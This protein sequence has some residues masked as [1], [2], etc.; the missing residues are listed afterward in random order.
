MLSVRHSGLL[1]LA[2]LTLC[3]CKVRDYDLDKLL[4]PIQGTKYS[5]N[6]VLTFGRNGTAEPKKV[7]GWHIAEDEFTWTRRTAAVLAFQVPATSKDVVL[8]AT[9]QGLIKPPEI[10]DQP[11]TVLVNDV[12]VAKWNVA[13]RGT[14]TAKIPAEVSKRGGTL[15]ITFETRRAASPS[16]LQ[17][18]DDAR[19][20][21]VCFFDLVLAEGDGGSAP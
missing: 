5:Y 16:A 8:R 12:P 10:A 9:A 11:V 2:A 6:D 20:L 15:V 18:G 19:E 1:V 4:D 17:L 3:G 14:F 7:S 13:T 21:A